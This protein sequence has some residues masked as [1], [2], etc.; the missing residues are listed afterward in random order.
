MEQDGYCKETSKKARTEQLVS[1]LSTVCRGVTASGRAKE[2]VKQMLSE[3]N[4]MNRVWKDTRAI[5]QDC[6]SGEALRRVSV[7]VDIP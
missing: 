6:W 2:L 1:K 3:R 5:R 7:P 4:S